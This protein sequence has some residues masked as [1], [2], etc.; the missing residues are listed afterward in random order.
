[1][2]AFTAR[3]NSAL[4][5][6]LASPDGAAIQSG[7]PDKPAARPKL[8]TRFLDGLRGL[9]AL[10]VFVRHASVL[11]YSRPVHPAFLDRV[12]A[13][14]FFSFRFAIAAVYFFFVLSGFVI[15]LRYSQKLAADP[16]G[17]TFGWPGFFWRRAR[18]T[19]RSCSHW[20]SPSYSTRL[21]SISTSPSTT[22]KPWL[23]EWLRRR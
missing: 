9:A 12:V 6:P 11:L 13:T 15:H 3:E 19:R 14:G 16:R 10:Y 1:M 17:A 20:P 18:F 5:S 23:T 2:T 22:P 21:A 7:E 8:S 4:A